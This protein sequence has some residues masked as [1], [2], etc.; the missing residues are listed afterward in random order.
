MTPLHDTAQSRA[1][2]GAPRALT[3]PDALVEMGGDVDEVNGDVNDGVSDIEVVT[4]LS[5]AIVDHV[6]VVDDQVI[7][8]A[9][10]EGNVGGSRRC[11]PAQLKALLS[12]LPGAGGRPHPWAW[13]KSCTNGAKAAPAQPC[14]SEGNGHA[15]AHVHGVCTCACACVLPCTPTQLI[16][17]LVVPCRPAA[18]TSERVGMFPPVACP[19][20]GGVAGAETRCSPFYMRTAAAA[21]FI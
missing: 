2:P 14:P 10:G 6:C 16:H 18:A 4:L 9:V 8:Q 17:G 13:A 3:S 7:T 21:P 19:G 11:D 1:L 15:H 12:A 20:C 5:M